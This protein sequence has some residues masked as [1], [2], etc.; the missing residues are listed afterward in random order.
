MAYKY[1]QIRII[2]RLMFFSIFFIVTNSCN[3]N[4]KY[5]LHINQVETEKLDTIL[6]D[7]TVTVTGIDILIQGD[8]YGSYQ[9]DFQDGDTYT[10]HKRFHNTNTSSFYTDWYSPKVII[11]YQPDSNIHGESIDIL[12]HPH[13][14]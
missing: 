4:E 11:R 3:N 9:I 5:S 10:L 6:F 13:V 1:Q 8:I 2:S 14:L 7:S 12:L